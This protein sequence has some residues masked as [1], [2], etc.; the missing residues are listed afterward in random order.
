MAVNFIPQPW[1]TISNPVDPDCDRSAS[2]VVTVRRNLNTPVFTNPSLLYNFTIP[3]TES[4]YVSSIGAVLA[5]D[6]DRLVSIHSKYGNYK[7]HK[8]Q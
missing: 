4:P 2:V 6:S 1:V 3:E 8:N 7:T 5:T